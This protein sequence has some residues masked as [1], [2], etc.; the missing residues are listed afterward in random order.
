ME[1]SITILLLWCHLQGV[2]GQD[3]AVSLPQSVK[4][5]QGSCVRIPCSFMLGQRWD[6]YLDHTCKAQWFK[7][8]RQ[9]LVFDSSLAGDQNL[10]QGELEG[11]LLN[12]DCTTIFHN[13]PAFKSKL[14]FRIDCRS[15]LKYDNTTGVEVNVKDVWNPVLNPKGQVEVVEGR[16]VMLSCSAQTLCPDRPTLSW[17]PSLGD[18]QET[19]EDELVTSVLTFN[20]SALH[21]RQRITC[22]S[23][24]KRNTGQSDASFKQYL[25]L[26]VLYRPDNVSVEWPSSPVLEG[27][28]VRLS[29][30]G[31]A[32]PPADRYAWYRSRLNPGT[33]QGPGEGPLSISQSINV[34]VSAD[35]QYFCEVRNPYGAKNTSLTQM[36]VH[37]ESTTMAHARLQNVSSYWVPST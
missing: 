35:A 18:T 27:S 29:C 21:H 36:V 34:L 31:S 20:A 11:N 1:R 26:N 16:P 37:C 8:F 12:R 25:T 33:D 13:L 4:G 22:S 30:K 17:T 23:L 24:Y 7:D 6:T 32:N 2:G 9:A 14:Y 3:W 19:V 10:Y 15:G 5:L 28:F